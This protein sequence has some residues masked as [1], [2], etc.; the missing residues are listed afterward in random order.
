MAVEAAE[1]YAEVETADFEFNTFA[2]KPLNETQLQF[3]LTF[4]SGHFEAEAVEAWAEAETAEFEVNTSSLKPSSGDT[5][6]ISQPAALAAKA[7][8]LTPITT[9]KAKVI[10]FKEYG[11]LIGCGCSCG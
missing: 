11:Q 4:L 3:Y 2:M 6:T 7:L 10:Y 8:S 9:F 1:A 5:K